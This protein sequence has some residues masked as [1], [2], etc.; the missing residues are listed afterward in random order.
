[1]GR[2]FDRP[3]DELFLT[4]LNSGEISKSKHLPIMRH[5]SNYAISFL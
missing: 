5:L 3:K 2:P 4:G 1:M